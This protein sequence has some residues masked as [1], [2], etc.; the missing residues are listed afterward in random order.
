MNLYL[1]DTRK[2]HYH[3]DADTIKRYESGRVGWPGEAYREGLRAVL[4]AATDADLPFRPTRRGRVPAPRAVAALPAAAPDRPGLVELGSTPAGYLALTSVETPVPKRIGW[5]DVEHVRAITCAAAM[6]ENRFG[7]GLSC[8]AAMQHL[9]WAARLI[10]ARAAADVRDAVF[11]AVGNLSGVVAFSAFDIANHDAADRCFR[12]ALWCADQGKSWP[13]RANTLAEMSRMA[14]YLGEA[15]DALSL[16]EFA[17]VRS[18]RVSATARAMLWTIRARLLA[19]TGRTDEAIA[20]VDRADEH[21]DARD[22]SADPPW[23]CYYDE[24]EHQGSTGKALVPVAQARQEPEPE[25]AA[26]RLE[27]AVR[28]QGVDYPRSRTFSRIRLAA[29]MMS[30]GDP[31]QAASV[32]R[33]AVLDAEPLRSRRILKELDNLASVSER[34]SRI[35]DVAALRWDIAS[36]TRHD[37]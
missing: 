6:S 12:F 25:P 13:L 37:T 30:T 14:A 20:E 35:E 31:R 33:Q 8:E 26:L 9:R 29:L 32:G 19:S 10:D 15:D 28:L 4:D 34:H 7:G 17:Q 36:L 1:W 11:E 18:D 16:I 22:P 3:L 2:T 5:T 24:A 21:F 27:A 23:L